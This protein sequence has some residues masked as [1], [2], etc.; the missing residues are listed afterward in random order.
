MRSPTSYAEHIGVDVQ[1]FGN[2]SMASTGS[3][4]SRRTSTASATMRAMRVDRSS[5]LP[6]PRR[7]QKRVANASTLDLSAPASGWV[8]PA[9]D[10]TRIFIDH[11]AARVR[12]L[13]ADAIRSLVD[14]GETL[15]RKA[16]TTKMRIRSAGPD[17]DVPVALACLFPGQT[18]ISYDRVRE[19]ILD[20]LE[21]IASSPKDVIGRFLAGERLRGYLS[22]SEKKVVIVDG[23]HKLMALLALRGLVGASMFGGTH[24]P[25]LLTE[26]RDLFLEMRDGT[27]K[28]KPPKSFAALEDNPFRKLAADLALK[29]RGWP[30]AIR[31]DGPERPLWIKGPNAEEYVDFRI[32]GI[33]E[34]A[35][36][37]AGCAWSSGQPL[38]PGLRRIAREALSAA[39][40]EGTLSLDSRSG[41]ILIPEDWTMDQ[42]STHL[43]VGRKKGKLRLRG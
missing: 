20:L 33:I 10:L 2:E 1:R 29:V 34:R 27:V 4:S 17:E 15:T 18:Q 19:K 40:D 35:F 5:S 28:K 8:A 3:N 13:D 16:A 22:K 32:A 41:A 25:L 24:V 7:I 39:A 23:H 31:L 6:P 21:A 36:R 42:A 43:R 11:L 37:K 14:R 12:A 9:S 26:P 30:D 38:S